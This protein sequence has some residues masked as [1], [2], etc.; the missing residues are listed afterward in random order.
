VRANLGLLAVPAEDVAAGVAKLAE[1]LEVGVETALLLLA[2]QPT[3]LCTQ[4][5]AWA[6]P[7][8]D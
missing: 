2:R 1:D 8:R 4:V 3:L 7:G 6:G 5:G